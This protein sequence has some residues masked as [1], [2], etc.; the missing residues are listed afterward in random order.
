[1]GR[2]YRS[3]KARGL[4]GGE[5]MRE[6]VGPVPGS[7]SNTNSPGHAH[8]IPSYGVTDISTW[9]AS[10]YFVAPPTAGC[11]K[12]FFTASTNGAAARWFNFSSSGNTVT[13]QHM[14]GASTVNTHM[15]CGASSVDNCITLMGVNSTHWLVVSV[16]PSTASTGFD[17]RTT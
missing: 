11:I 5:S 6:F 8:M 3:A 9:A 7:T 12:T 1:M 4:S 10:T 13:I 14:G 16:Y 2:Q 15:V 17:I